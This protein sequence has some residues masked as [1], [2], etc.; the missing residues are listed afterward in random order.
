MKICELT[1]V[2]DVKLTPGFIFRILV[3][4][5]VYDSQLCDQIINPKDSKFY[6]SVKV[7]FRPNS[8][9]NFDE[10]VIEMRIRF[11]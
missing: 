3:K 10:C 2:A 6:Y 5:R 7:I 8:S 9:A 1:S 11:F 4:S